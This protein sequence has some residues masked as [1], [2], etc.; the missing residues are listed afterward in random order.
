M[1]TTASGISFAISA[2]AS[3]RSFPVNVSV[4]YKFGNI[5]EGL[6]FAKLRICEVW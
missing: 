1:Y 2:T 6:V 5:R 3:L 4:Y